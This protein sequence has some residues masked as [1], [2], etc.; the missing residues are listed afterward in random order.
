M[1]TGNPTGR[2][3]RHIDV[4]VQT[5]RI[6]LNGQYTVSDDQ[7]VPKNADYDFPPTR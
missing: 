4:V 1:G 6:R 3:E 7:K 5:T 2:S